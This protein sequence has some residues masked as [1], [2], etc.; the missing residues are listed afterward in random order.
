MI[1]D[2]KKSAA[3]RRLQTIF[4]NPKMTA[5]IQFGEARDS[6]RRHCRNR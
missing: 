3:S 4:Y 1:N 5:W 6:D 2:K